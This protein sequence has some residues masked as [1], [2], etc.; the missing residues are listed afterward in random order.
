MTSY[1]SYL[2]NRKEPNLRYFSL[3]KENLKVNGRTLIRCLSPTVKMSGPGLN[4]VIF[5]NHSMGEKGFTLVQEVT[6][7][8]WRTYKMFMVQV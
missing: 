2:P 1:A 7:L 3:P 6:N 5:S 8:S 4:S